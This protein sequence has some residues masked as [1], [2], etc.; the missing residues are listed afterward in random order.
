MK[1][2]IESS[3]KS[4]KYANTQRLNNTLL[5]RVDH[6]RNGRGNEEDTMTRHKFWDPTE[7]ALRGCGRSGGNPSTY[8]T[9]SHNTML[10]TI[11]NK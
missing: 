6:R 1:L 3:R 5:Q 11:K 9:V 10:L 8:K 7:V 2:G 4:R